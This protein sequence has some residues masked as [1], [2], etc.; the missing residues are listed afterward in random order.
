[1]GAPVTRLS[2]FFDR[3]Q[4]RY[5]CAVLHREGDR[6]LPGATVRTTENNR[7]RITYVRTSGGL[8]FVY[9]VA[10]YEDDSV[11]D[12]GWYQLTAALVLLTAAYIGFHIGVRFWG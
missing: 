4:E 7:Y 11:I 5:I 1:M 8:L 9:G 2:R 10:V 12:R 3:L 6:Y